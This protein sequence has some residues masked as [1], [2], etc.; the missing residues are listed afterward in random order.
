[1]KSILKHN[2]HFVESGA[3]KQFETSK[4]PDRKIAV[5][6]CMDTRLVELLPAALGVRNGDINIIKNA[7]GMITQ[8][9]DSCMRSI[10]V[11]VY[12]LGVETVMIIGH[13]DC[14]VKGMN[15]VEMTELMLR[16]GISPEDISEVRKNIDLDR[17]LK[18][19]DNEERA[20]AD[21]V[22]LVSRHPLMPKGVNVVGFIMDSTT[23]K[24]TEVK[25]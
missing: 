17:W 5:V 8:P 11:S 19:F 18:G 15:S 3:Y 23:G 10:L 16:R 6:T 1:M 4:R 20:V 25:I 14:G 13:T 21:T 2:R 24:L 7:G 12:E 9:F 22:Y